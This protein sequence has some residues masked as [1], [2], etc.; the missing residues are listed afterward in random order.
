MTLVKKL[1]KKYLLWSVR[2]AKADRI[3]QT[4]QNTY[5]TV[6]GVA[7]VLNLTSELVLTYITEESIQKNANDLRDVYATCRQAVLNTP[8]DQYGLWAM[9]DASWTFGWEKA[10]RDLEELSK[11][12]E[13]GKTVASSLN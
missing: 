12:G 2:E 10:K 5:R 11:E 13:G 3:A 7:K 6:R 8:E 9:W 4:Y 1:V